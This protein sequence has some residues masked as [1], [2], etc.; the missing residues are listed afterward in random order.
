MKAKTLVLTAALTAAGI[1]TS[2]AQVFS[3]NAV[4]Y[5]NQNVPHNFSMVANP[6]V[7][8]TNTLNALLPPSS[9]PN[10]GAGVTIY[11]FT[12]G[13][14]EVHNIDEF[15]PQWFDG[16]AQPSG[17]TAVLVFGDGAF[18]YNP[19]VA[20]TQTWVG[21]VAQGTPLQTTV[22]SGFSI[23]SSKVPQSGKVTTDLNYQPGLGDSIQKFNSGSQAFEVFT[24][25]EFD[26]VWVN[27]NAQ[28]EEPVLGIAES[29]F[30]VRLNGTT[31]NRNFTVN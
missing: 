8:A 23:K 6:F 22:P 11:K 24:F 16:N 4:G 27:G 31:W 12:A 10:N 14:F 2:M 25:D 13:S 15:D 29:A 9:M 3:V 5:V 21:E 7:N 26:Q 18:L 30:F 17:D 20:F 28:P 19:G 1:A